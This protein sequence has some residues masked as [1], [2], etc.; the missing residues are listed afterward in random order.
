MSWYADPAAS[1]EVMENVLKKSIKSLLS[2]GAK[3]A[4]FE[5]GWT[6]FRI[7]S[8]SKDF[9][10]SSGRNGASPI[11]AKSISPISVHREGG[12]H[13]VR[14]SRDDDN[15]EANTTRNIISWF[16]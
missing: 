4:R 16:R 9:A 3:K 10:C 7:H 8:D 15:D 11:G 6:P 14:N 5:P 1:D 12:S 13:G 2:A